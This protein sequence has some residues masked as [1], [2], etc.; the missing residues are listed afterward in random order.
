M[1]VL[2]FLLFVIMAWE[3]GKGIFMDRCVFGHLN[4]FIYWIVTPEAVSLSLEFEKLLIKI[5]FWRKAD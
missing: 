1:Y 4:W 5:I 3:D 2:Q